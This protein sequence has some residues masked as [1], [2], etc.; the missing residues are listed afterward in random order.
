MVGTSR[1]TRLGLGRTQWIAAVFFLL[2]LASSA[3][4]ARTGPLPPRPAD[5]YADP[6]NDIYNPL[7]YIASN[8]LTSVAF[9]LYL[10]TALI[11]SYFALR[12]GGQF[13]AAMVIA[14]YTFCVGLGLRYGLHAHP[15]SKGIYIA[16]YLFVVLSPC[17]FIAADYVL[18]GRLSRWLK[19]DSHLYIRPTRI[20]IVF[21][22]SD[23][24]TFLIQAAGGSVSTSNS[25]DTA[26]A[27]SRIFLAGLALQLLSFLFFS[28]VYA[29]FL[30]RVYKY[31]PQ[32]WSRDAGKPWYKD[33]RSLGAA[34]FLSCIGIL[35]RSIYRT[36]EL[37]EGYL[38]HLATTEAFFYGLDTLP[39]FIAV[40]IYVPF[41]PG[42]FIPDL[43]DL[44]K[45]EQAEAAEK[46]RSTNSSTEA[47]RV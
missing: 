7:R 8:A 30:Y 18:L 14:E 15:E 2:A 41:W 35:I 42:R 19:C 44:I 3:A 22:T 29:R 34:L 46:E 27:G 37:G 13:M 23:V 47:E 1:R 12:I 38:G 32:V 40:A 28:T 24:V 21:V 45:N 11:Q 26:L 9:A 10:V 33:W 4:A 5:P 36:I 6:K 25:P 20:T 39:L 43:K 31:E 17:G 16:E